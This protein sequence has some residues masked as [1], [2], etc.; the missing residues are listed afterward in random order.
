[1]TKRCLSCYQ[2]LGANEKHMH[3][4]CSKKLFG[5]DKIPEL[6]YT[7]DQITELAKQVIQGQVTVPGVQAKLSLDLQP[8]NGGKGTKRFTIIGVMGEYILKPPSPNYPQLPELEDL[9]MHL[10]E[11]AGLKTVAHSLIRMEEDT[12]AYITKRIDRQGKLKIHM[13]DMAQ[14]TERMTEQKYKGGYEQILRAILDFSA[15]PYLDATTFFEVL[16]FSFLTGNADMHLKNFSMIDTPGIGYTL[17][18]AYDLVPSAILIQEDSED[19]ALHLNGKKHKLKRK[20]FLTLFNKAGLSPSQAD[21]IFDTMA[22]AMPKWFDCLE[23][24]FITEDY[25]EKYRNLILER[26]ARVEL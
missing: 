6:P 8:V 23:R 22:T 15:N 1:M 10:A 11:M 13:E 17:S 7:T 24:S 12:L 25:K 19:M 26:A 9:T 5:S 2:A 4:A 18:S 20:D 21:R 3:V 14:L 16:V